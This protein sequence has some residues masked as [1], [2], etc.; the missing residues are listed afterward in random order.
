VQDYFELQGETKP[1]CIFYL[2]LANFNVK[3]RRGR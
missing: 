3:I 2:F 1:S